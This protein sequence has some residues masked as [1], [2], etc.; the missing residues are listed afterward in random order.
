MWMEEMVADFFHKRKNNCV[1]NNYYNNKQNR[2]QTK[3]ASLDERLTALH[4]G[5]GSCVPCRNVRIKG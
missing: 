2:C 4:I 5:R 1:N 3:E